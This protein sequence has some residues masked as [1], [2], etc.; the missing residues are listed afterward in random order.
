M[1]TVS[2]PGDTVEL[3]ALIEVFQL[4]QHD[5]RLS[6]HET[7][8]VRS[9]RDG[10][11]LNVTRY[12]GVLTLRE[13]GTA[14]AIVS[15]LLNEVHDAWFVR[16]GVELRPW[17]IRPRH[18][19]LFLAVFD[20]PS[21]PALLLSSGQ[22]EAEWEA[23]AE[24]GERFDLA[25][26]GSTLA[27]RR[28][29]FA[30]EGPRVQP[31]GHTNGRHEVHVAY[32]L[33]ENSPV[34][35]IVL[36]DY[37]ERTDPFSFDLQWAEALLA[38]PALRGSMTAKKLRTL[39]SVTRIEKDL[40]TDESVGGVIAALD[41]VPDDATFAQVDDALY[42]AGLLGPLPLPASY[43]KAVDVGTPVSSLAERLRQLNA[44]TRREKALTRADLDLAEGRIGRRR[45]ALDR[46]TALL[47]H[48]RETFEWPNCVANAVQTRDVVALLSILDSPDD[49][50]VNSK[51]VVHEFLGVKLRGLKAA[52]R[53]RAIF[54]MCGMDE[55]AQAAWE[56]AELERRAAEE[57]VGEAKRARES[58]ELTRYRRPDG[59]VATGVQHVDESIAAGFVEIR[60]WRKG[61]SKVYALV[62]PESSE[63]RRLRAKDGTLAY[64]RS[65][66][67]ARLAA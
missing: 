11:E 65:V 34:P 60:D 56:A 20:L 52:A 7:A 51:Q 14:S 5:A 27:R 12:N 41:A 39:A 43:D 38:Y 47:S 49:W 10:V 19:D 59:S 55:A 25:E 31:D 28:F 54:A 23:A 18:W 32:A 6:A 53:R 48:G 21:K 33:L 66:L 67:D 3:T 1:Y 58:A 45:H 30:S 4:F 2:V 62:K 40:L 22:L 46:A 29:G 50:N 13:R 26:L 63:A 24:R 42:A 17:E 16:D 44:D 15:T 36:A 9:S 64:A 37:H 35:D 8:D 61:A 57:R